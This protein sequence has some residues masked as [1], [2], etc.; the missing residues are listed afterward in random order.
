MLT[1]TPPAA[2]QYPRGW[3]MPGDAVP[4]AG[5]PWSRWLPGALPQAHNTLGCS[6]DQIPQR[7]LLKSPAFCWKHPC[8]DI[9]A[10]FVCA[11]FSTLPSSKASC[12]P[13]LLQNK[14]EHFVKCF[15]NFQTFYLALRQAVKLIQMSGNRESRH[16]ACQ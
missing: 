4:G 12:S 3:G 15:L 13:N 6:R 1:C 11:D 10:S 5:S 8:K 2:N 14:R 7:K 9:L 16:Y